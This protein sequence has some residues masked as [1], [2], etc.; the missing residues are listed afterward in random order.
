MEYPSEEYK[1]FIVLPHT[2][3]AIRAF[4]EEEGISHLT[5][6]TIT[7]KFSC[8]PVDESAGMA[9]K[10]MVGYQRLRTWLE[11]V[12][13]NIVIMDINS[14]L[15]PVMQQ[16]V[17]NMVMTTPGKTDDSLLS[18][19][20]HSKATAI[21]RDL[22]TIHSIW[23]VSS[24]TENSERY[25]RNLDNNYGLPSIEY[26]NK[27]FDEEGTSV[28]DMPWWERATIDISEYAK[29]EDENIIWM[30]N[31]PLETIG[32]EHLTNDAEA[33]IIVFDTWKKDKE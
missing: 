18:V 26:Y 27:L 23:L 10:A 20:L 7:V 33:D 11:A 1:S 19:L 16:T 22:L 9:K 28:N 32:K 17:S 24:D 5:P 21:T 3:T 13:N 29:G 15:Y 31:D 2:F 25:Y 14:V 4:E 30:E 6:T 12:M 8:T